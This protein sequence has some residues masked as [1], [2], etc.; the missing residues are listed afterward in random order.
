MNKGS[1]APVIGIDEEKCINCHACIAACPVKYCM[2]G[3]GKKL[4]INHDECIG[5]G[6]CITVCTH[7]ARI[8]LDDVEQF[9]TDVKSDKNIVAIAAPAVASVFADNYLRLN[10]Y[11]QS[12]GVKAVFDVSFG[13]ELTV[14]SYLNYIEGKNPKTVIAQPCP[15]I[16]S[17]IQI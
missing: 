2:D 6:H 12:L 3:S 14:V 8:P 10:G 16:V 15:A 11:L 17:Y 9:L 1:L 5:C 7:K 4:A 13:A